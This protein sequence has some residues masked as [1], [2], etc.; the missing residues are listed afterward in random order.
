MLKEVTG[1]PNSSQPINTEVDKSSTSTNSANTRAEIL[2]E[3]WQQ[4]AFQIDSSG[5]AKYQDFNQKLEEARERTTTDSDYLT[6]VQEAYNTG[7]P[8]L[9]YT[10]FNDPKAVEAILDSNPRNWTKKLYALNSKASPS[11]VTKNPAPPLDEIK[12]TPATGTNNLTSLQRAAASLEKY[13]R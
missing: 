3:Q 12:S 4:K 10:V 13:G 1:A 6:L 7:N 11:P 2:Q 5:Q 8:D 9:V